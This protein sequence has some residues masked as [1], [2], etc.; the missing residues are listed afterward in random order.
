MLDIRDPRNRKMVAN[1]NVWACKYDVYKDIECSL[2]Y[3]KPYMK[4]KNSYKILFPKYTHKNFDNSGWH[5]EL[6]GYPVIFQNM[7]KEFNVLTSNELVKKYFFDGTNL[8]K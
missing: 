5:P 6:G 8:L 3:L 7:D 4:K 1:Q 2:E